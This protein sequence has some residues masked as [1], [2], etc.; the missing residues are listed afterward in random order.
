MVAAAPALQ[1]PRP[2]QHLP[3]ASSKEGK[4]LVTGLPP[5]QTWCPLCGKTF[6]PDALVCLRCGYDL[7]TGRRTRHPKLPAAETPAPSAVGPA[8]AACAVAAG[9]AGIA[10][11]AISI[12][13]QNPLGY[14]AP[15]VG[16]AAGLGMIAGTKQRSDNLAA[17]AFGFALCALVLAK[18]MMI[19]WTAHPGILASSESQ[20]DLQAAVFTQMLREPGRDERTLRMVR[21]YLLD[22]EEESVT[23]AD[24]GADGTATLAEVE[25]RAAE[26]ASKPGSELALPVARKQYRAAPWADRAALHVSRWDVLWIV[27]ALILAWLAPLKAPAQAGNSG[28]A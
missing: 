12:A 9:I 5:G 27:V 16:L 22:D 21:G 13:L 25:R 26:L 23:R 2:F 7:R 18:L 17:V 3:P 28:R 4:T 8:L 14:A 24:L 15:L 11:A 19:A 10:W 20:T 6:E 1:N